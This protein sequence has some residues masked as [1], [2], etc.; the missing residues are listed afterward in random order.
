[1][2]VGAVAFA[3]AAFADRDNAPAGRASGYAARG[4]L[5]PAPFGARGRTLPASRNTGRRVL[6]VER[7]EL[8][9]EAPVLAPEVMRIREKHLREHGIEFGRALG[10]V[11]I[12]VRRF[13]PI[14]P[15]AKILVRAR[16]C[17]I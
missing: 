6:P 5:Q 1:M 2:C 4:K 15:A 16:Q 12:D 7:S 13:A 14:D 8:L 11:S 3:G 17:L 9:V 10:R